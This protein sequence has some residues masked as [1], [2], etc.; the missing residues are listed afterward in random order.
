MKK[1]LLGL[2]FCIIMSSTFTSCL[3][4]MIY[5]ESQQK[6]TSESKDKITNS[7]LRTYGRSLASW[8]VTV[9]A[10]SYDIAKDIIMKNL[11][12]K[13]HEAGDLNFYSMEH[14]SYDNRYNF[15]ITFAYAA[16]VAGEYYD[17]IP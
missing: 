8:Y 10:S 11:K 1:I 12:E 2:L 3:S 15:Y 7:E 4:Y 6:A 5:L 17:P 9:E 13:A 16:R 14:H